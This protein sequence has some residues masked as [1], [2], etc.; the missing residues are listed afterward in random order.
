MKM[1]DRRGLT[2]SAAYALAIARMPATPDA[3]SIAPLAIESPL[4]GSTM[5]RWSQC[6]V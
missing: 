3:L 5:P 1:T 4:M 2:G 6:A